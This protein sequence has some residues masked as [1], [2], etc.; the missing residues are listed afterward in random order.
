M[1]TARFDDLA[2]FLAISSRRSL[3]GGLAG[4]AL[5]LLGIHSGA[6]AICRDSGAVCRE[7]A[8]C[9]S[10]VCGPKHRLGRRT[11]IEICP[12]PCNVA[13]DCGDPQYNA[14]LT[15]QDGGATCGFT[16][17]TRC[18]QGC[19]VENNFICIATTDQDGRCVQLGESCTTSA[20]CE[21]GSFCA[22][23]EDGNGGVCVACSS[24]V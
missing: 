21:A 24:P 16:A 6:A 8:N 11:C 2:R 7:H 4:G 23:R 9:C 1:E 18:F 3:L 17:I 20:T 22:Q 13:A 10:G 19:T 15:V 12:Y 5:G 14:C